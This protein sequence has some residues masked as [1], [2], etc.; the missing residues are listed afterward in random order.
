MSIYNNAVD[1]E[2][3]KLSYGFNDH[4]SILYDFIVSYFYRS[5][6]LDNLAIVDIKN[7]SLLFTDLIPNRL[8]SDIVQFI[9]TKYNT[10]LS[11]QIMNTIIDLPVFKKL[12]KDNNSIT[13]QA[14]DEKHIEL[15]RSMYESYY[16]IDKKTKKITHMCFPKATFDR[17][18]QLLLNPLDFT[19]SLC[20]YF[21]ILSKL[22]IPLPMVNNILTIPFGDYNICNNSKSTNIKILFQKFASEKIITPNEKN[23]HIVQPKLEVFIKPDSEII[24]N[25]EVKNFVQTV[26]NIM[27]YNFGFDK[28]NELD[29][30]DIPGTQEE[31]LKSNGEDKISNEINHKE[32]KLHQSE[33]QNDYDK[34]TSEESDYSDIAFADDS[35]DHSS[36]AESLDLSDDDS[37]IV[38]LPGNNQS[39]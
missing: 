38:N 4:N 21:K 9:A 7:Y 3:L 31:L 6:N 19:T 34:N 18:L 1:H 24:R 2:V 22:F 37:D 12:K 16:H 11:T 39:G 13:L 28:V 27:A 35:N 20:D 10:S 17:L 5:Q 25:K 15:L 14:K 30:Q 36:T 8:F 26:R 33:S 23:E 29:D 32:L